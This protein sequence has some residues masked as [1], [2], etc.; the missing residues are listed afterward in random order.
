MRKA[1]LLLFAT[2]LMIEPISLHAKDQFKYEN[3]K[4]P[5]EYISYFEEYGKKSNICPELLEAIAYYE[6]RFIKDVS[7]ENCVGI[8]QIDIKIHSDRI[9]SFGYQIEDMY[10]PEKNIE[11]ACD[12]LS[13]F[14][15]I[16]GDNNYLVILS[17][18]GRKNEILNYKKTG[19]LSEY[20][21][22]ILWLSEKYER[23]HKK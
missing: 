12:I 23:F 3:Y 22:N 17:Y 14:Y 13:D 1:F 4:I 9:R 5:D 6:S 19:K 18:G 16:Y 15:E 2:I 21:S 10:D 11:I 7:N 8:M 20:A